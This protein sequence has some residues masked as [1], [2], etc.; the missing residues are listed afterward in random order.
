MNSENK[1]L[2]QEL[3]CPISFNLINDPATT[4]CNHL[5]EKQDL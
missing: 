3:I 5:F 4:K 1:Q 2:F